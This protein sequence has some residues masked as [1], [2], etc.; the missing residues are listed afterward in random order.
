MSAGRSVT[1][2]IANPISRKKARLSHETSHLGAPVRA[3][4]GERGGDRLQATP[5]RSADLKPPDDHLRAA[6]HADDHRLRAVPG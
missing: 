1:S 3:T 2:M 4:P 6:D 5:G